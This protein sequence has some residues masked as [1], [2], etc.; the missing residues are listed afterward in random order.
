MCQK[1]AFKAPGTAVHCGYELKRAAVIIRCQAL[2]EMDLSKKDEI[3]VFLQ[4]FDAEWP[5]RV[6]A[7]ALDNLNKKKNTNDRLQMTFLR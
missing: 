7:P 3:D 1:K 5:N 4:L 6:T 2:R